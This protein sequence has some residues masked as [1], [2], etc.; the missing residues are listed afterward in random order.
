M[1]NLAFNLIVNGLQDLRRS[2]ESGIGEDIKDGVRLEILVLQSVHP[3]AVIDCV[4]EIQND[5]R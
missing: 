5:D 3:R 2:I 1:G 4:G